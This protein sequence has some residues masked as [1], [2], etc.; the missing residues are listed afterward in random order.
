MNNQVQGI[1]AAALKSTASRSSSNEAGA[2]SAR[3]LARVNS[4]RLLEKVEGALKEVARSKDGSSLSFRLD[5]PQLGSVRV[6]VTLRDGGLHA[7]VIPD[8]PQVAQLMKE[9]AHELQQN[10]R[11][12]GLNVETVSVSVGGESFSDNL[13]ADQSSL[14]GEN[15]SRGDRN[16]S[17]EGQSAGAAMSTWAESAVKA[18]E[19]HWVA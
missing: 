1:D 10:L 8:N 3:N 2:R 17:R 19:D 15:G 9:R 5:P 12:L 13:G 11:N 4:D 6:D 16:A 14:S 7:R 18:T